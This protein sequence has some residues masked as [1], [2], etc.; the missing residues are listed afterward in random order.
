MKIITWHGKTSQPV[1]SFDHIRDTYLELRDFANHGPFYGEHS[2]CIALHHSQ[3]SD[4]PLNFFVFSEASKELSNDVLIINPEIVSLQ[5]R[6]YTVKEG[7]MSW[8][9][10]KS[11]NVQRHIEAKVRY[12]VPDGDGLKTVEREV[13]GWLAVVF[14]HEIDHAKGKTIYDG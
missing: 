6:R 13:G 3:V 10:R 11:K 2:A 9:F 4:A 12:Q 8:P 5:G 14:Q 1:E 7:C